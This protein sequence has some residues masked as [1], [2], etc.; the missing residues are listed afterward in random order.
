MPADPVFPGYGDV[1][2][3]ALWNL[4]KDNVGI[5]DADD[6]D[7]NADE[8][9]IAREDQEKQGRDQCPAGRL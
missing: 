4:N 3:C 1:A 7:P 5:V 8:V 6:V 9:Q 2:G